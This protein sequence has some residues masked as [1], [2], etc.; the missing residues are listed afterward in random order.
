[1]KERRR[2]SLCVPHNEVTIE[3][4]WYK[5][6]V[7]ES[8]SK[9]MDIICVCVCHEAQDMLF[10]SMMTV[11]AKDNCW[12]GHGWVF[13]LSDRWRVARCVSACVFFCLFYLN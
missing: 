3:L 2:Q 9:S 8:M 10:S 5:Q 13:G 7:S 12:A 11:H 6:C 1:M 4:C